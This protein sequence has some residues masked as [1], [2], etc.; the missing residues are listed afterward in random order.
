[1]HS[2]LTRSLKL[3]VA[4]LSSAVLAQCSQSPV[5][6][7]TSP[8]AAAGSGASVSSAANDVLGGPG[9]GT[10]TYEVIQVCKSSDSNVAGTFTLVSTEPSTVVSPITVQP[11]QCIVGAIN[12][13]GSTVT[14]TETSAGLQSIQLTKVEE[15]NGSPVI[16]TPSFT[17][18]GSVDLRGPIGYVFTFKNVVD[19][20]PGGGQG[21]TPGYW[22][23]D[24]HYDS[25]TGYSPTD[26][27]DATFGV[28]FF[29]PN[30]TLG[31]AVALGGG[32]VNALAR[33]GVAALLNAAS[34]GVAYA[35]TTAEV[36]AIVRGTGAYAGLSME[37]RKDLL[38]VANESS[39]P[40]N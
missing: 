3:G 22:R 18:G 7:P 2:T 13:S 12:G 39:C 37:A 1:M 20:P 24:H 5:G 19:D 16:T 27:F 28:N 21:C 35:Y 36:I 15:I 17:N 30:K 4:V 40:L 23:Q 10:P 8:S 14:V 25:W 34:G 31:A 6:S 32:G 29:T 9:D 11:G 38:A 33:H 26:D